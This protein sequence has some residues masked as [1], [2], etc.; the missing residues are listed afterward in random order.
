MNRCGEAAAVVGAVRK[1]S[2][3]RAEDAAAVEQLNGELAAET[4]ARGAQRRAPGAKA[5]SNGRR[6]FEKSG[7]ERRG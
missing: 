5:A 2:P 4:G 6:G 7:E 1:N 3:R